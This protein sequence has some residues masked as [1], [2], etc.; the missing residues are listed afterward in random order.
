[1]ATN[2]I[3]PVTVNRVDSPQVR[4]AS[5]TQVFPTVSVPVAERQV[6]P[7]DGS[8]VPAPITPSHTKSRELAV[9]LDEISSR[10][11]L[12]NR[13]LQFSVDENLGLGRAVVKVLDSETKEV[14]RQIPSEEVLA[15]ARHLEEITS[16][17]GGL[18]GLLLEEHA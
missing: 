2:G 12:L 7:A 11:Q 4:S 8:K 15:I 16:A 13:D 17:E 3:N 10:V 5:P 1:M 14:I 9:A 18:N 6:L